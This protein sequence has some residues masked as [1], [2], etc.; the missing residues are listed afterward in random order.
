MEILIQNYVEALK[1]FD[2]AKKKL[3]EGMKAQGIKKLELPDG[4]YIIYVERVRQEFV[5][6]YKKEI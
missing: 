6:H 3:I 5:R 1:A 2:D 4:S